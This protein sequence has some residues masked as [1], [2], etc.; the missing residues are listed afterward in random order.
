MA[1]RN[2]G[3]NERVEDS[4]EARSIIPPVQFELVDIKNHFDQSLEKIQ[5]QY[6]VAASLKQNGKEEDS[7]NILV[8]EKEWV[9]LIRINTRYMQDKE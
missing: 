7:K 8:M 3:L 1:G 6:E 2:L 5:N 4:R 9:A